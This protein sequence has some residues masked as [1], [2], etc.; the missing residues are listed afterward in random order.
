MSLRC[1]LTNT[2]FTG[3]CQTGRGDVLCPHRHHLGLIVCDL[4]RLIS[5]PLPLPLQAPDCTCPS[6]AAKNSHRPVCVCVC[7]S[8]SVLDQMTLTSANTKGH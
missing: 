7:V 3:V 2:G 6:S 5:A 1:N 8:A 4:C